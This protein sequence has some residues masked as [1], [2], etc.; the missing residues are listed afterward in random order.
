MDLFQL[1]PYAEQ[2][3]ELEQLK[4]SVRSL[5]QVAGLAQSPQPPPEEDQAF[6]DGLSSGS[7]SVEAL[8]EVS[9]EDT[10]TVEEGKRP[11]SIS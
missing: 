5:S 2:W 7:L 11:V 8:D 1:S 9:L 4:A 10:A 6:A 3:H